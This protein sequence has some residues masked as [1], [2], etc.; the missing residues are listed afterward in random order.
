MITTNAQ[1]IA[2]RLFNKM[3]CLIFKD[4]DFLKTTPEKREQRKI[5]F[6]EKFTADAKLLSVIAADTIID[7]PEEKKEV[8]DAINNLRFA[9]LVDCPKA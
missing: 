1:Q 2:T 6:Q 3:Y 7:N 4:Y 5:M 9:D 8:G